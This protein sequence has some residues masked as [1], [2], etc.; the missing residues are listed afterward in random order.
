MDFLPWVNPKFGTE[1]KDK[2]LK[3]RRDAKYGQSQQSSCV[4]WAEFQRIFVY[5][6]Q[7]GG[8]ETQ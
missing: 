7:N 8:A 4:R 5:L 2:Q 3:T 6:Y 1:K